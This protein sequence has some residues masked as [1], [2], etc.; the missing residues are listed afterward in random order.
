MR[1]INRSATKKRSEPLFFSVSLGALLLVLAVALL[2]S[3][4][5]AISIGPVP[6]PPL[7]VWQITLYRMGLIDQG[8][9]SLAHEN[10]VW[11]IR[12]PR[13]LMAIFVGGGLAVVGVTM[14]ALV[15]NA[16]AD[17]Y[18]LGISSGA[19]VGAVLAIGLG[20]FAFA[21]VYAV[22]AGA[23][24]G[25]MLAFV[26]VFVLAQQNGRVTPQRFILAGLAIS[27]VFS[28][29]TSFIT[30]TSD[31][32]ELA[33]QL[34]SWLLGSLARA[35]WIDLTLPA[36][37]LAVGTL[38]LLL[39]ARSLNSLAMGD[40]TAATLGV[41]LDK[42]RRQLFVV[43]S[44]VT[45]V[46][47]AVSGAIGFIGLMIPH[48]VRLLF[49]VDHRWVLPISLFVGAIF[50]IWVDVF[51]RSAFAPQ[52][53]PVGVITALLGGPFFLWLMYTTGREGG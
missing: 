4:T 26:L 2:V 36:L 13:T 24:L 45:G 52:E 9:W 28:G 33:E 27:Y 34:L 16:L 5:L 51:A 38:F 21:G 40:E 47:V 46:M 44:L 23:F 32:R 12:M 20:A 1:E 25:A 39:Q 7:S 31:D 42:L 22:S 3:V 17:P 29:L 35:D 49:G 8:S 30:L 15:R 50:L 18:L 53:L 6:I 48:I 41:E 19:S 37:V 11:L 10:I 14:Q 43:A